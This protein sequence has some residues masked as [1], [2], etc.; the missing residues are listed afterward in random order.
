VAARLVLSDA[1]NRLPS[2]ALAA[3]ATTGA[4]L[5]VGSPTAVLNI[6]PRRFDIEVKAA[7]SRRKAFPKRRRVSITA[8]RTSIRVSKVSVPFSTRTERP[9]TA[10]SD[11]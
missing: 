11:T 2:A 10:I 8:M 5:F 1:P 4:L 9:H 3:L 7:N 6:A